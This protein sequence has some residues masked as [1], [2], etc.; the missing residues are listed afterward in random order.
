[1]RAALSPLPFPSASLLMPQILCFQS[2]EGPGFSER[3]GSVLTQTQACW[4]TLDQSQP[5]DLCEPQCSH[6]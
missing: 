6:L 1:M 4:M 3:Q 2:V 5:P